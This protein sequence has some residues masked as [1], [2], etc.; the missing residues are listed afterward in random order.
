VHA[1]FSLDDAEELENLVREAGFRDADARETTIDVRLPPPREFL[2]QYV[3]STPLAA[4]VSQCGREKRDALEESIVERWQP[5]VEDGSTNV[6][7]HPIVAT[8]RA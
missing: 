4:A 7:I 8:G 1:V 5:F 2:W 3:Y 6:R